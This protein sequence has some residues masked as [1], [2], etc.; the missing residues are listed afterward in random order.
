VIHPHR[1]FEAGAARLVKAGAA[2]VVLVGAS[3]RYCLV[4]LLSKSRPFLIVGNLI[5]QLQKSGPEFL[6]LL[7]RNGRLEHPGYLFFKIAHA[8]PSSI[9]GKHRHKGSFG[10]LRDEECRRDPRGADSIFG[11]GALV[12]R[13]KNV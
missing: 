6:S 1:N 12:G 8:A 13:P 10:L 2:F 3:F 11:N 7:G 4:K 5:N 9:S